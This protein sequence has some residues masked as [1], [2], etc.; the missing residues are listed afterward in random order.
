ML[1]DK[2]KKIGS[3]LNKAVSDPKH[4]A[5]LFP[6]TRAAAKAIAEQVRPDARRVVEFGPGTGVTSR[7]L[8]E[9]LGST[10]RLTAVEINKDFAVELSDIH[11]ARFSCVHGNVVQIAPRLDGL[12]GGEIDAIVSG[13]PFSLLKPEQRNEMI[14]N[15]KDA[16]QPGGA[17]VLYQVSRLM[18]PTVRKHFADVE[19]ILEPR[20]FPPYFIIVAKK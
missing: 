12:V 4:V 3:H 2:L 18:L 14:R 5:S 11:D 17:L 1:S 19:V 7:A 10:S 16:L 20:N 8:L 9:H 13:I 6:T 15:C